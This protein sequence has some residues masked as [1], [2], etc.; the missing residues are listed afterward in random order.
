[1]TTANF[2]IGKWDIIVLVILLLIPV[3]KP[4]WIGQDKTFIDN[5][6]QERDSKKL[7]VLSALINLAIYP[8]INITTFLSLKGTIS[9][10]IFLVIAVDLIYRKQL[11]REAVILVSIGI[12]ALYLEQLI[13]RGRKISFLKLIDWESKE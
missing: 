4:T 7:S 6:N 12:V 5:K 1:M 13:E 8:L 10:V 2:I 3:I 11:S 9:L